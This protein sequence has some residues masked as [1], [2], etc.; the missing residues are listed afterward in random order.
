MFFAALNHSQAP[1]AKSGRPNTIMRMSFSVSVIILSL[2][3]N[4]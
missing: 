2:A 4:S 1:T 3:H